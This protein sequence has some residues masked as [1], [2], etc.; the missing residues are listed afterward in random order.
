VTVDLS[1]RALP[2]PVI[3][4]FAWVPPFARGVTRDLRARWACEEEGLA[5]DIRLIDWKY[6]KGPDHRRVQ[7]FGQ[8]PTYA[9]GEVEIFETG[10]IVLRIAELGGTLL[11]SAA[12][13][14]MR[15]IQWV[16]AALNSVEPWIMR[17]VAERAAVGN[18]TPADGMSATGQSKVMDD[19]HARLRDLDAA[20]GDKQWLDGDVFTAGDLMMISVLGNL[21]NTGA[22][23]SLPKLAAF[24]ARG[25]ARPAHVKAMA[26]QLALYGQADA[27]EQNKSNAD[28]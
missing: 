1:E 10:A 16:I 9:D 15:A 7:P 28:A 19:L 25:E 23:A 14:R 26:D 24:V 22:L 17:A 8:I 2:T 27:P 3:T 12:P 21:R 11:P 6:S 13:A 18:D 4:T 5:Y 20:L